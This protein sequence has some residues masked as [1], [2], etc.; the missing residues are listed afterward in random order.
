MDRSTRV[1]II[2][3]GRVQGVGFRFAA[4]RIAD[5]SGITGR[6]KNLSN[7]KVEI[8][9]EGERPDVERFLGAVAE[10]MS[11]CI[12]DQVTDWQKATG[13]FTGFHVCF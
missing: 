7:G 2:Y 3:A 13:E 5:S 6:V 12:A 10:E 11:G 1:Q 8:V 9:A 4:K